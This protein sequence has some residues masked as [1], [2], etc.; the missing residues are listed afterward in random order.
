MDPWVAGLLPLLARMGSEPT[1]SDTTLQD[2]TGECAV[3]GT[4]PSV[5]VEGGLKNVVVDT[6]CPTHMN[7]EVLTTFIMPSYIHLANFNALILTRNTCVLF[8]LNDAGTPISLIRF[9]D[10]HR[11]GN[12]PTNCAPS[13]LQKVQFAR[14][15]S[16][17]LRVFILFNRSK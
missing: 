3:Q 6:V 14:T 12:R 2:K 17:C 1:F 13:E 9:T 16:E 15:A 11:T 7:E 10:W 4:M 8:L 5:E